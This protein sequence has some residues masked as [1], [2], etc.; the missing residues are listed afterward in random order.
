MCS[1]GLVLADVLIGVVPWS[2]A[3][4]TIDL[5][6]SSGE[7]A[8]IRT[9]DALVAGGALPPNPGE[10]I[11]SRAMETLLERAKAQYDLI[12]I[13][14]PPLTAVSDAFPLL[15]KV[16]GVVIVGVLAVTVVMS[17]SV[18]TRPSVVRGLLCLVLSLMV[19][20]RV[21][22]PLTPT[23][24]TIPTRLRRPLVRGRLLVGP[25]RPPPTALRR[26]AH[27]L[28]EIPQTGPP[29]P[30][31]LCLPQLRRLGDRTCGPRQCLSS[32]ID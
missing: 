17:L 7:S 8:R 10:L 29:R 16:D 23:P 31:R 28:G 11:E 2:E 3:I 24:M 9:L 14:T 20:R 25:L 22:T 13:D 18:C 26:V 30:M 1:P 6:S 32:Q 12:V 4:Q 27:Q 15:S 21:A 5:E 19:S